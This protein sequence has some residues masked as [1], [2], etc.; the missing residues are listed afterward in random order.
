MTNG[1]GLCFTNRARSGGSEHTEQQIASSMRSYYG[2]QRTVFLEPLVGNVV[3]H[4][5]MF[6]TVASESLVLVG[7]YE[8]G[9]DP[10]NAAILD[11]NAERIR[12]TASCGT[13]MPNNLLKRDSRI[14]TSRDWYLR[15]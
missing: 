12:N 3:D 13:S 4:V 8:L 10:I 9:Q 5:D 6:M 14:A 2:C 11:Q 15:G 1:E 7:T